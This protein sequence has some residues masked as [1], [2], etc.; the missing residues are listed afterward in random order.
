M[1][2]TDY[3]QNSGGE[4]EAGTGSLQGTREGMQQTTVEQLPF[5]D[6]S[7]PTSSPNFFNGVPQAPQQQYPVT[8]GINTPL[9]SPVIWPMSPSLPQSAGD[10]NA[11]PNTIQV[12]GGPNAA[13]NTTRLL[14]DPNVSPYVTRQ[15]G[16]LN[17]GMLP[18]PKSTSSLRQPVIIRATGKKS[19]GMVRPPK[20]RRLVVHIAV[21]TV[22][23]FI[24]LGA[25]VA[26]LP[27]GND[28]H[29][30]GV[31]NPFK[32]IMSI[33][34]TKSNNTG[35]VAQQAATATAVTQ[36]GY[37][38][39]GGYYAGVA[40]A[41]PSFSTGSLARFF[42]GQCTYWANM[43]YHELT[44]MYV[45]WTGNAFQWSYGASGAG[46]IVS[47]TPKAHAIIVLQPGVQGAGYYG[48]VAIVERINADGSVLTSNWNWAGNWGN[49]TYVTFFPG[50]GVSFV[51]APGY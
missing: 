15:L 22:L 29:G 48:H 20:G 24:V 21:T 31:F 46:W 49:E 42:Y 38:P 10:P 30:N 8:P 40:T 25:L 35:L 17:T 12:V 44:G 47:G 39:G 28:A 43:R 1:S 45:P 6:S 16:E 37:D 9:P 41:P 34:N 33:V 13:P 23:L 3:R 50:T 7:I 11:S 27:T 32:P 51:Y 26:V 19:K 5:P 4:W 36:D 18:M 14:V 2:S